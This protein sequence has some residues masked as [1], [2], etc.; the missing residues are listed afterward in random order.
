VAEGE[1]CREKTARWIAVASRR[2]IEAR[3]AIG[4]AWDGG[5]FVWHAWA[6]ARVGDRWIPVDPAFR[7]SPARGP[8]FTVARWEANGEEARIEAG[9]RVLRCWGRA[10][11]EAAR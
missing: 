8:R 9:R 4:V 11:V 3:T 10:G 7:Q 2:G 5:A 6:E 1:S